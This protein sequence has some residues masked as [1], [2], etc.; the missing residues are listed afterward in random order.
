MRS[1]VLP[2][3]TAALF[4]TATL[5]ACRGLGGYSPSPPE[6]SMQQPSANE[7]DAAK[8]PTCTAPK[9]GPGTY[10]VYSAAGKVKGTKFNAFTGKAGDAGWVLL[11]YAKVKPTPTPSPLPTES[12][13]PRPAP[14][15]FYYG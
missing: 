8:I 9:K 5:V 3:T 10:L 6:A 2:A 12:P 13:T 1:L 14:Y 4:I 11:K 15:Y 7:S